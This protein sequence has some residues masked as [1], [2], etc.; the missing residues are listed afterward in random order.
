MSDIKLP[1]PKII[2]LTDMAAQANFKPP[3]IKRISSALTAAYNGW[4]GPQEA[5]PIAAPVGTTA[6]VLDYNIAYNINISPRSGELVGFAEMKALA[7][8]YDLMRIIME[9]RKNQIVTQ[10]W[11]IQFREEKESG[12]KFDPKIQAIKEKLRYPDNQ[13]DLVTWWRALLDQYFVYDSA[14]V[15]PI[16]RPNGD[17]YGIYGINGATITCKIDPQGRTPAPPAPAFQQVIKGIPAVDFTSEQLIYRPWNVRFDHVYGYSIVEQIITTVNIGLRREA[18]QLLTFTAGSLPD[19]LM[20]VPDSWTP[21][22]IFEYQQAWDAR[23][24]GNLQKQAALTFIPAGSKEVEVKVDALKSDFDEWLIRVMCFAFGVDPNGFVKEVTRATAETAR[25]TSLQ[26]GAGAD[27]M[28]LK[29][30]MDDLLRRVFNRPDLEFTWSDDTQNDPFQRM[31]I[32]TN[33]VKLGIWSGD[34]VRQGYGLDPIGLA[35]AIYQPTGAPLFIKDILA[36]NVQPPPT[37]L[38]GGPLSPEEETPEENGLA[39]KTAFTKTRIYKMLPQVGQRAN[40]INFKRKISKFFRAHKDAVT[41]AVWKGIVAVPATKADDNDDDNDSD[42]I[43]DQLDLNFFA[44]IPGEI[45]D[46]LQE[47]AQT[48]SRQALVQVGADVQILLKQA[49]EA[50][51]NWAHDHAAEMVGRKFDGAGNLIDNPN[52]A[53]S[54]EDSTRNML[55]ELIDK[56][57]NEGWSKDTLASEIGQGPFSDSRADKIAQTELSFAHNKANLIGWQQSGVVDQKRS[58]LSADHTIED[59]CDENADAGWIA[60]DDEFPSGDDQPAFHPNCHCGII[61]RK[62]P[63]KA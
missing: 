35:E 43:S 32:E 57:L 16:Y 20:A 27:M 59:E 44:A 39:N 21:S 3:F 45:E 56:A 24:L 7:E 41:D 63:A 46:L 53:Y 1:P 48:S 23:Y 25:Q 15:E 6:R 34:Y 26:D 14:C 2:P 36:G 4:M 42:N 47:M 17:L 61:S 18:K 5:L 40:V 13:H 10:K 33:M 38:P 51:I 31:Q 60:L 19:A 8:N 49:D 50:A 55:R 37:A 28:F 22:Q 58:L 29:M 11:D 62:A 12:K 52:A 30:F 54:I 9:R